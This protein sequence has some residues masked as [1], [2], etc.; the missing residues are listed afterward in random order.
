MPRVALA[1]N[2]IRSEMMT[3]GEF[4]IDRIAELDSE[5]TIAAIESALHAGGH[6]TVRVEADNEMFE[7]LRDSRPDVV[8]NIAEGLRGESR[9]SV[10]PAMCEFLG[11]P[12]TGSGVLTTALCLDKART[13][14]VLVQ[15]RI[16]TPR[17]Q[18]F[19]RADDD[20]DDNMRFPMFV[21][22]LHEGSSIGV[23][24]ASIVDDPASLR[25]RVQF[26]VETYEQP[27]LVERYVDGREFTVGLLGNET[28]EVLP[29]AELVFDE[30]R[31][32]NLFDPDE[33]VA[34][35][36]DEAGAPLPATPIRHTTVCPAD[37]DTMLAERVRETARRA[38][39]ALG[40]RDWCRMDMR[41]GRDGELYVLDVNPIAGID[42][43]YLF[44]REAREAGYSYEQLINRIVDLALERSGVRPH[45]SLQPPVSSRPPRL[46]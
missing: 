12:Y 29:I 41:C 27:A 15:H 45:A 16:G 35:M 2:L 6:E 25:E 24:P 10:V 22:P 26:I 7:Q 36:A 32:I 4:P 44:P 38:F 46:V 40:C 37:I 5:E 19:Q 17:W 18:V 8:F 11:I 28:L 21:K 3:S 20:L 13:K 43:S 33:P 1:F 42:P 34:K 39:R 14:E 9:E 30:R 31:G 23:S